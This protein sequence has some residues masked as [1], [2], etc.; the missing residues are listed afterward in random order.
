VK[1]VLALARSYKLAANDL[2][3]TVTVF[4]AASIVDA[5]NRFVLPHHKIDQL[6]VSGGG[7][8]NPLL[9]SELSRLLALPGP[10][11]RSTEQRNARRSASTIE[12][13]PS[14]RLN[15]PC[16]AKEALAFAVLAYETSHHRPSN[17]PQATGARGRAILGKI[18][19]APP[20]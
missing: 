20:R 4:T 17:L 5:L 13:I 2:L 6:I 16:D 7:A 15:I 10:L 14:D 3:H 1:K 12:V 11:A 19:Y 8:R 18:S 9:L